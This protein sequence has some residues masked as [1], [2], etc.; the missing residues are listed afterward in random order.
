M[1]GTVYSENVET[2]R[3]A[4]G[5]RNGR[6]PLCRMEEKDTHTILICR[7]AERMRERKKILITSG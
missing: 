5:S 6:Y 3:T 7:E 2:E 1:K 4:K